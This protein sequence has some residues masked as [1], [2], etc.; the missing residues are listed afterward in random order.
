[1]CRLTD[2]HAVNSRRHHKHLLVPDAPVLRKYKKDDPRPA[3]PTMQQVVF[4]D[5]DSVD[6][7]ETP[8]LP[9]PPLL[10]VVPPPLV[11]QMLAR[12]CGGRSRPWIW[13]VC[14]CDLPNCV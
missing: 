9:V 2:G 5:R 11:L 3:R 7:D 4:V 8:L 1:M 13:K 6:D 10:M 14:A 12:R